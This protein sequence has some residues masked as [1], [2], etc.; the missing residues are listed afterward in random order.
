MKSSIIIKS[1]SILL[2]LFGFTLNASAIYDVVK[3]NN[4]IVWADFQEPIIADGETVNYIKV[5][6]KNSENQAFTAFNMNFILPEGFHI[7]QLMNDNIMVND[8]FLS[9][10]ATQTHSVSCNLLNGVDLRIIGDSKDND[11]LTTFDRNGNHLDELLTIGIIADNSIKSGVYDIRLCGI[12]FCKKNGDACVP[13]EGEKV[14][15]VVVKDENILDE[16]KEIT[17]DELDIN[18]CYDISGKKVDPRSVHNIIII[19]KGSSYFLR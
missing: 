9:N 4:L 6:Q 16:I 12:K 8:I 13:E 5:Y 19:Y 2:M 18:E 17:L 1:L 10:R 14:Y 15:S 11:N 3:T 7:N